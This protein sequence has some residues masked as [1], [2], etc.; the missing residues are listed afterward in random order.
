VTAVEEP[1]VTLKVVGILA[2]DPTGPAELL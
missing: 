1:V 2:E